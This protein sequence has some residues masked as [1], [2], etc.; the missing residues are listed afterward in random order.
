[1]PLAATVLPPLL[2]DGDR[3]TRDEFL[4]RWEAMPDVR[5]AEL[6]GGIVHMPSPVSLPHSDYHGPLSVWLGYYAAYTAGCRFNPE[7]TWIMGK[8][9]VPQPDLALRV[10]PEFGG[11]SRTEGQY[12][13]GAPELILEVAASSRARDLGSK[14]RLFQRAGV[15]EYIVALVR[16]HR[17][18]WRELVGRS[19]RTIAQEADGTLHSRCFPGLW[20]DPAALWKLATATVLAHLQ[21]GLAAPE[22]QQ[23]VRTL[24]ARRS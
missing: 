10:L 20:L 2:R 14:L 16:E 15:R 3:L 9:D 8:D 13:S 19:Y 23:F 1:M 11:Q 24:A 7:C 17:V 6:I 21:K 4:R 12:A 5:R 18:I 22:H